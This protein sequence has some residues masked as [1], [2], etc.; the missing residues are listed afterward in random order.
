M[1]KAILIGNL[2]KDNDTRFTTEGTCILK[3]SI[4][5]NDGKDKNGKERVNFVP[6]VAFGKTAELMAEYTKK[7]AKIGIDGSIS[8]SNYEKEGQKRI[9][10]EVIINRV[11]FLDS[12][13][14]TE[15]QAT[16]ATPQQSNDTSDTDVPF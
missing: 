10:T 13:P 4:A 3:N 11:E 5:L 14:K 15:G 16:Q 1:N 9:F 6:V 8:V 2:T 7:G 12:K